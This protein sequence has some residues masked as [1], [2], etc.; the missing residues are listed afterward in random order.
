[1]EA[2]ADLDEGRALIG[3]ELHILR[4]RAQP[5]RTCG[6]R[7]SERPVPEAARRQSHKRHRLS[8]YRM[9]RFRAQ[10]REAGPEFA[11]LVERIPLQHRPPLPAD[12]L[13]CEMLER[14]QVLG[15]APV[16]RGSTVLEVGSG[17][18]AISTV[19]LALAVG[20]DGRVIAV[21]R[22]RWDRFREM[23]TVSGLQ[24]RV[25]PVSCDARGLPLREDSVDLAVCVHGI[26]SLGP[27]ERLLPVLREMLRVA[28][29]LFLAES[30]PAA[31]TDAQRAH[32]AMYDLREEFFEATIGRRDD[33][34]YLP[35]DRLALLVERAGGAVERSEVLAVD[36]PHALAY[37]PR[38][39]VRSIQ[40]P[41]VRDR[42]LR[43][44]DE[45]NAL[46]ERYGTDHPPVGLIDAVRR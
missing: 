36:L 2:P 20:A 33:L 38:E 24:D 3:G 29:R 16:R 4:F 43:R 10:L 22:S 25:R 28:P 15:H 8:P 41:E 46:R 45:A 27:P 14:H 5:A 7:T 30:L 32:L 17:A 34:H 9:D 26:R 35:L 19:P 31:T 42:L 39:S 12:W 44:W 37:F 1:M 11:T 40:R 6:D 23:V 13:R 21:E 18:H